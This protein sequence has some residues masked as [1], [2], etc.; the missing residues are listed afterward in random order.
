MVETVNF[1][2]YQSDRLWD[3]RLRN[4]TLRTGASGTLR[5]ALANGP[6]AANSGI[7]IATQS[8]MD[9]IEVGPGKLWRIFH[10]EL[11]IHQQ[12]FLAPKRVQN[13]CRGSHLLFLQCSS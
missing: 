12:A 10:R 11:A 7:P 4:W 8:A 1:C 6:F 13:I 3:A 9:S 2:S 5:V